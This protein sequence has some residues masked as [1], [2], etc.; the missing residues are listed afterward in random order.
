M[1]SSTA[2]T[3]LLFDEL[4]QPVPVHG[5][6]LKR[7][8]LVQPKPIGGGDQRNQRRSRKPLPQLSG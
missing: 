2:S 7:Q 4:P 5:K 1:N 8:M 3:R 6:C